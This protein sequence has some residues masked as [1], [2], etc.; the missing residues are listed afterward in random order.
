MLDAAH[1]SIFVVFHHAFARA[2]NPA[3][4]GSG[5]TMDTSN[6]ATEPVEVTQVHRCHW[7][8]SR[9]YPYF[10]PNLAFQWPKLERKFILEQADISYLRRC[11]LQ[12]FRH[13]ACDDDAAYRLAVRQI[14]LDPAHVTQ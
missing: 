7:H 6:T 12:I 14:L 2:K 13:I 9:W 3:L 4:H 11:E 10:R 5:G 1:H 8:L